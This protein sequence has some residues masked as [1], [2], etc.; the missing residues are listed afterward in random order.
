MKPY[1]RDYLLWRAGYPAG[2]KPDRTK[3]SFLPVDVPVIRGC[4]QDILKRAGFLNGSRPNHVMIMEA[5]GR[6][7][8]QRHFGFI[9]VF[10]LPMH[11]R[12]WRCVVK[13]SAW[14]FFSR[15]CPD[16]RIE[17]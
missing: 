10:P 13:R 15:H 5:V 9:P 3:L 8:S 1:L 12:G 6:M 7:D 17:S 16:L 4:C 14:G 2:K 11:P